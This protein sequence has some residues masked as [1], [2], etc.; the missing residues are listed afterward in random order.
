MVKLC[1]CMVKLCKCMVKLC[2][3]MVKLCKCMVKLCKCM[4]KFFYFP[5]FPS[6][7]F[8]CILIMIESSADLQNDEEISLREELLRDILDEPRRQSRPLKKKAPP[9]RSNFRT[10]STTI[11]TTICQPSTSRPDTSVPPEVEIIREVSPPPQ[12]LD[13][14]RRKFAQLETERNEREAR[15]ECERRDLEQRDH[16]RRR[17]FRADNLCRQS[18]RHEHS[19]ELERLQ[20]QEQERREFELHELEYREIEWRY[21]EKRKEERLDSERRSFEMRKKYLDA[22]HR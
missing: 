7:Q 11:C 17:H 16:D 13:D 9:R 1:K 4:L 21:E 18:F 8:K 3:C 5:Y 19:L 10:T 15:I 2:K 20:R 22:F 6:I 14:M 12:T